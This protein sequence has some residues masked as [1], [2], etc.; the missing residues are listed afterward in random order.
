MRRDCSRRRDRRRTRALVDRLVAGGSPCA[1]RRRRPR[2]CVAASSRARRAGRSHGSRV[3]GRDP[4]RGRA[5]RRDPGPGSRRGAPGRHLDGQGAR[6]VEGAATRPRRPSGGARRV[7][8]SRARPARAAVHLPAG[9][10][11]A[12]PA[13]RRAGARDV[14]AARERRS[15]TRRARRSTR[16]PGF[17]ASGIRAGRR[18]TELARDGD[19]DAFDFPVARVPGLD[20]SFS[21]LKTALL[22]TTRDLGPDETERLE[23]GPRGL[24]SSARSSAR[25]WAGSV[26][27]PS[28]RASHASRSWAAWRRTPSFARPCPTRVSSRSSCART[29]RR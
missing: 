29:T 24:L 20:F 14:G 21:G 25:S 16:A 4:G 13:A 2:G 19:P 12:H 28:R 11:R 7:A 9:E 27:P 3:G 18:S 5:G 8:V 10:R 22:Y 17:S 23:G 1:L 26:P 15:T 6:L